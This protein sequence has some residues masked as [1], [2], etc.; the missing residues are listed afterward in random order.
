MEIY[1]LLQQLQ[2]CMT[3]VS[4]QKVAD[5][6]L[7]AVHSKLIAVSNHL[8]EGLSFRSK[9]LEV[10]KSSTLVRFSDTSYST[11]K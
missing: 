11:P 9:A 8:R 3:A 7:A 2:S 10:L 6:K 5:A 1:E 4:K